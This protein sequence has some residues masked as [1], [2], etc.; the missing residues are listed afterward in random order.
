MTTLTP[1]QIEM[2]DHAH[3]AGL[4]VQ[5]DVGRLLRHIEGEQS[6][7]DEAVAKER[8]RC[9]GLVNQYA[10][11]VRRSAETAVRSGPLLVST[12]DAIDRI[13]AA[14]RRTPTPT[15]EEGA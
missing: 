9:G 4:S 10:N 3:A 12:A 7:I 6:R 15:T 14:I 13:A 5:G 1:D 2:I 11:R 8:E